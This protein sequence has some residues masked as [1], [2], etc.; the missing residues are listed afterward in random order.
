MCRTKIVVTWERE[1]KSQEK[2]VTL[3]WMAPAASTAAQAGKE[4]FIMMKDQVCTRKNKHKKRT[5]FNILAYYLWH[6]RQQS[7]RGDSESAVNGG[8]SA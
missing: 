4:L 3:L 2:L 7:N 1:G 6:I 5:P 8:F